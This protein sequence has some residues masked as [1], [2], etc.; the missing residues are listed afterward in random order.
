MKKKLLGDIATTN[1]MET[2]KG[3]MD[4]LF[5]ID[6]KMWILFSQLPKNA[7]F[8]TMAFRAF[9]V[10]AIYLIICS[11]HPPT[12][13]E[14]VNGCRLPRMYKL[15]GFEL[16]ACKVNR[17][18]YFVCMM[19][20]V[21]WCTLNKGGHIYHQKVWASVHVH[22][23]Q[24]SGRHNPHADWVEYTKGEW[25]DPNAAVVED[26][27]HSAQTEAMQVWQAY[28]H[29]M[30][31]GVNDAFMRQHRANHVVLTNARRSPHSGRCLYTYIKNMWICKLW[32]QT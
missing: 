12:N 27:T 22:F 8:K 1:Y 20:K 19:N 31:Q 13:E 32:L 7:H 18:R 28:G 6:C 30:Q 4:V 23:N 29:V 10:I 16:K 2:L 14:W 9:W 15:A 5:L 24:R 21:F 3:G 11:A 26:R 17:G 25:H